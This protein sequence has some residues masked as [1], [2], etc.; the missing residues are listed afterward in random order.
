M[1]IKY[2][3]CRISN[4]FNC[5]T[6]FNANYLVI[7]GDFFMRLNNTYAMHTAFNCIN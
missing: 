4:W 2:T 7:G 1:N 5:K 3:L 6:K